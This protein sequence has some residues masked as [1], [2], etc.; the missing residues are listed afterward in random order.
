MYEVSVRIQEEADAVAPST[1]MAYVRPAATDTGESKTTVYHRT[2]V[3]RTVIVSV[4]EMV[5]GDPVGASSINLTIVSRF[6][7]A[8]QRSGRRRLVML[9]P[10]EGVKVC[11]RNA[12]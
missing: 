8:L 5:N 12:R 6:W 1:T 10:I 4:E 7:L 9:P 3:S 2:V 11:A